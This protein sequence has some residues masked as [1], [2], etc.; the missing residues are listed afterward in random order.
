MT[1]WLTF[2][3][4]IIVGLLIGWLIDLLWR[5]VPRAEPVPQPDQV[6]DWARPLPES[7]P[8]PETAGVVAASAVAV[9]AV[10]DEDGLDVPPGS[11]T[12]GATLE[13]EA[14]ADAVDWPAVSA[15]VDEVAAGLDEPAV[16]DAPVPAEAPAPAE[17]PTPAVRSELPPDAEAGLPPSAA[18]TLAPE[19]PPAE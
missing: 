4:G 15:R 17:P 18:D 6:P 3:V 7:T 19:E 8:S 13:A 2:V 16:V 10:S 11:E 14:R 5:R 9:A 1:A 12:A